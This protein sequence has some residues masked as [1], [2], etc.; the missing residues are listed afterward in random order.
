MALEPRTIKLAIGT[1][2]HVDAASPDGRV[3]AEIFARQGALKGAQQKKVAID[4]LKLIAVRRERP[5]VQKLIICFAD[6]A[7]AGY[8][9][10]GGWLAQALLTW[11]VDVE[12]VDIPADLRAEIIAAQE[13]QTMVNPRG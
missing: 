2:V 9:T 6:Q 8:A 1:P 10:G 7:A 11:K 5:E 4:T 3:L 13:G 12:I